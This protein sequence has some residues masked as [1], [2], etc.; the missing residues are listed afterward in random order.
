MFIIPRSILP[1]NPALC[2]Q[3]CINV[4]PKELVKF[5][6]LTPDLVG[7]QLR[8]LNWVNEERVAQVC[9]TTCLGE[10]VSSWLLV[11]V[12]CCYGEVGLAM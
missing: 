4:V 3:G 7:V 6:S 11:V 10:R 8:S 1:G 5:A 9:S 12:D 2:A